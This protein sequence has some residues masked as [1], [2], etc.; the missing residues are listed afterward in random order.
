MKKRLIDVDGARRRII[1]LATGLHSEVLPID[2]LLMLL[3][4]IPTVDAVDVV[5]CEDCTN[6]MNDTAYCKKHDKGYCCLDDNIKPKN[7][8]CGYAERKKVDELEE[9]NA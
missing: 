8:Y 9:D 3:R 1:A 5:R 6:Y 7:H 2:T 4:Q